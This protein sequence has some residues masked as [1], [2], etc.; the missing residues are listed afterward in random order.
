VVSVSIPFI[1]P[2]YI[3]VFINIVHYYSIPVNCTYCREQ[4]NE[5]IEA[6]MFLL[7]LPKTPVTVSYFVRLE[8]HQIHFQAGLA[9]RGFSLRIPLFD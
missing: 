1:S 3:L 4:I 8:V 2:F 6:D 9:G 7:L 5:S